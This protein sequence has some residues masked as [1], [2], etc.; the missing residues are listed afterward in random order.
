MLIG[1]MASSNVIKIICGVSDIFKL[2][3]FFLIGWQIII[4]H[5]GWGSILKQTLVDLAIVVPEI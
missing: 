1:L 4:R 3:T 5:T 2:P